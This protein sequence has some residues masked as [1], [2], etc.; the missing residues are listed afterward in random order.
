MAREEEVSSENNLGP[1]DQKGEG[2]SVSGHSMYS[3]SPLRKN[4]SVPHSCSNKGSPHL[5]V[6]SEQAQLVNERSVA[7]RDS[8]GQ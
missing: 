6:G 1:T 7:G 3:L 5:R 4:G 2:G 8:G